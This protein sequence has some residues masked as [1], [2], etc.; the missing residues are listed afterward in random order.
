MD[1][2]QK[3]ELLEKYCTNEMRLLKQLCYPKIC[4]IGGISQ[5]DHD[6]LYSIALDVLR[7]SIER[8][9]EKQACKFSTL[10]SNNIQNKYDTYVRDRNRAKRSNTKRDENGNLLF[11]P[12]ISIDASVDD[13]VEL[14][15]KI[16]SDYNMEDELLIEIS[17]AYMDEYLNLL[18]VNE[19]KIAELI[20]QGSSPSEI[21]EKLSLSEKKY[22]SYMKDMKSFEKTHNLRQHIEHTCIEEEKIMPTPTQTLEKSK[23]NKLCIAAINK[24]IERHTIRFDHPLQRASEQWPPAMKGNLISD[25]LQ[26]NPIP[27]LVFAEQVINGVAIIWD[28][29]GKQRCTTAYSFSKDAFKITKNIRRG[30]IEYQTPAKGENGEDVIDEAGFPVYERR[31]FDIRGKKYSE[32]PEEL[33]D[34]FKEYNFEIVQ[35]LNCSSEDIAYHIARYNEGKPMNASQ[36]GLTRLGESFATMVKS[37]SE[38]PFFR[39]FGGYKVSEGN[40]GTVNRVVVESVMAA[41]FL[42][43]WKKKQEDMCEFIKEHATTENFDNFEDMVE[44]LTKVGT[45][46]TFNM[47]DSKDSFIWFGLF[48]KFTKS[49][50]DDSKFVEF[51]A[52]F[53]QSLHNKE[54]E[55]K[56]FDDLNGK[57][58]KDR[59]VVLNKINHLEQLMKEFLALDDKGASKTIQEFVKDNVGTDITDEDMMF[60]KDVLNDLTINV[61]NASKLLDDENRPSLL[62]LVA[63]SVQKDIDLDD[64]I[65][66]YFTRNRT[67]NPNQKEN[68]TYMLNDLKSYQLLEIK[69][70]V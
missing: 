38:M 58:T 10:L 34:R 41:N 9:D 66:D 7:D 24:K 43:D 55:G 21:R 42:D 50:L 67:Y 11:L 35:Y 20:M 39:D 5:M 30:L 1:S 59:Y 40:N 26:D 63:Y 32:L 45:E 2:L 33:Q 44:R 4:K 17:N 53:S 54:I 64:W 25:I 29:D 48:A 16:A 19:R 70:A 56:T 47:F 15:E 49:G 52:E 22:L 69:K 12:D 37:I 8:Y 6:D 61:D 46:D 68:Y 57:A 62:A 65:V 14:S 27:P 18:S 51:M 36:K 31:E 3:Q 13:G 60:Y 23:P 28:L